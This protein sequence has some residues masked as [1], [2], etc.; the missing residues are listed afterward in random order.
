MLKGKVVVITGA[1]SGI[2]KATAVECAKNRADV[3]LLARNEEKLKEVALNLEKYNV[4]TLVV[5]ADISRKKEVAEAATKILETFHTIDILINNAGVGIYGKF[6]DKNISD[7]EQV[8]ATNL[9]GVI[10]MTK[11]VLP[12][13][14]KN[15]RGHIVNIASVAG[16]IGLEGLSDYCASKFALTGL[17][18]SLHQELKPL[19]ISVSVV[20]PGYTNTNFDK[21]PSFQNRKTPSPLKPLQP[22]DVS[23][24]IMEALKDKGFEYFV[25]KLYGQLMKGKLLFPGTFM[26]IQKWRSN[27][28]QGSKQEEILHQ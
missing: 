26:K 4:K 9:F 6:A 14:I 28:K 18:E 8:V 23:A 10:Y 13:M 11:A 16:K 5:K 22:E 12:V 15:G 24:V 2:G 25:P 27:K 21:N 7:M 20:H 3:V 1:S 19:G 17:S